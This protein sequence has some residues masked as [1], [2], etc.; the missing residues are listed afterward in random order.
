MKHLFIHFCLVISC[1]TYAQVSPIKWGSEQPD[2]R[3]DELLLT[4]EGT[5]IA[6]R[7][8]GSF[9][10]DLRNS[11]RTSFSL[12][13][14]V[15]VVKTITLSR[16]ID[17]KKVKYEGMALINNQLTVFFSINENN[18]YHI[19]R[20]VFSDELV[21]NSE[22]ELLSYEQPKGFISE[23]AIQILKS[24]NGNF[25]GIVYTIEDAKKNEMSFGYAVIDST[26]TTVSKGIQTLPMEA[27]YLTLGTTLL[28]NNGEFYISY[29]E[30]V[31]SGR[32]KV[33]NGLLGNFRIGPFSLFPI[34]TQYNLMYYDDLDAVQRIHVYKLKDGLATTITHK[35]AKT[36]INKYK[37]IYNSE[38]NLVLMGSFIRVKGDKIVNRSD[39]TMN[40]IFTIQFDFQNLKVVNEK[41]SD[42]AINIYTYGMSDRKKNR[43][44]SNLA[45]GMLLP[46]LYD[47]KLKSAT[48]LPNGNIVGHLEQTVRN[49]TYS[50]YNNGFGGYGYG[51]GGAIG[52]YQPYNTTVNITYYFKDIIVFCIKPDGSVNWMKKIQKSQVSSD[53][54]GAYVSCFPF[55]FNNQYNILFTDNSKNYAD[56]GVFIAT[57]KIHGNPLLAKNNIVT[58]VS[59]AL[60]SGQTKREQF[61][62]KLDEEGCYIPRDFMYD[63]INKSLLLMSNNG[64]FGN[65][66][67]LGV[68]T[69]NE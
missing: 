68:T 16:E 43:I 30:K 48:Y 11:Y 35:L 3:F 39:L 26:F 28:A 58:R 10:E 5:Y 44:E 24:S 59:I 54:Y 31:N 18:I 32:K 29:N 67:R 63:P 27:D 13:Q 9:I 36:T 23:S 60:E 41:Y 6:S 40:G 61:L 42:L 49:V 19:Y 12:I 37:M 47:Y 4:K 25:S 34:Q 45:S 21:P 65:K 46:K 20:Q 17:G 55:I 33:K 1:I 14:G 38:G 53:Y 69:M 57:K 8:Y 64:V 66:I 22:M 7:T 56:N 50:S 51:Y 52:G 62:S 2:G 15:E